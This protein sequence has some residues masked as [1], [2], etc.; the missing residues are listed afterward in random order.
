[1]QGPG[2][3]ARSA[4]VSL[5]LAGFA[6][7]MAYE[8]VVSAAVFGEDGRTLLPPEYQDLTEKIG[9]LT[10][11]GTGAS[12]TAFCLAPDVI[13]TTSHCVYGTTAKNRPA[14]STLRFSMPNRRADPAGV[15]GRSIGNEAQNV[16]AG[17][18]R[19]K[20]TPPISAAHDWAV[21]KL[22]SPVCRSGGLKFAPQPQAVIDDPIERAGIYQV[23]LHQDLRWPTLLLDQSCD[24]QAADSEL[25]GE[26]E[27]LPAI[28]LHVCDTGGGSSGS[29]MLIDRAGKPEV[30]GL[31][32]GT[33]VI[34]GAVPLAANAQKPPPAPIANTAI[35]IEPLAQAL[36]MLQTRHMLETPDEIKRVQQRLKGLA[37][38]GGAESGAVDKAL[39]SAVIAYERATLRPETGLLTRELLDVLDA[40]QTAGP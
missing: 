12:C 25:T 24:L 6:L 9:A 7:I 36:R 39:I 11:T 13:A 31:N 30:V 35:R 32:V 3:V 40:A 15:A 37:L 29:P 38:Y 5:A 10:S 28:L 16:V 21:L 1:M 4:L 20:F 2:V 18:E 23:A 17:A 34:S 33:Y 27:D 19:L 8:A 26:F 22:E 14:L